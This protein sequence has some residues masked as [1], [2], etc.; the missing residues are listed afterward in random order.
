MFFLEE[1][2]SNKKLEKLVISPIISTSKGPYKCEYL[3]IPEHSMQSSTPRLI[4]A[5]HG[6]AWLQSLHSSLPGR[7]CTR[8]SRLSPPPRQALSAL[9]PLS[10]G[11]LAESMLLV[12]GEAVRSKR[13]RTRQRFRSGYISGLILN[14][15]KSL[16]LV[17]F[18]FIAL[19]QYN[20][21]RRCLC[22]QRQCLP[23]LPESKPA[24][25]SQTLL[26]A[27]SSYTSQII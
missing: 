12:E 23:G 18:W 2:G 10:R 22:K 21:C 4:E 6:A 11:S 16:Y 15:Q 3:W 25:A 9:S 27:C 19:P 17:D 1:F 13:C 5:Q 24:S 20:S 14:G 8:C 7:L 26:V